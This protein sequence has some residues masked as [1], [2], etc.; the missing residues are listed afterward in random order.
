M[1]NVRSMMS[2]F[3]MK[4]VLSGVRFTTSAQSIPVSIL[5]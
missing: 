3:T 4:K 2:R 5:R 1:Q